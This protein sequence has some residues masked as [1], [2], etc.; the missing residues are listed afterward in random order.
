MFRCILNVENTDACCKARCSMPSDFDSDYAYALGAVLGRTQWLNLWRSWFLWMLLI[1]VDIWWHHVISCDI[2]RYVFFH[3]FKYLFPIYGSAR[4][5]FSHVY[6]LLQQLANVCTKDLEGSPEWIG[7]DTF[8]FV[9]SSCD[10]LTKVCKVLRWNCCC[11]GHPFLQWL[12]GLHHSVTL[13]FFRS[14][15][16]CQLGML[17][18]NIAC[19]ARSNV[20]ADP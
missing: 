16:I 7:G 11:S 4:S 5:A 2:M 3:V 14:V 15:L 12:Y 8:D 6:S 10:D 1:Y 9:K 13:Q 18:S 17:C 20:Y 19:L